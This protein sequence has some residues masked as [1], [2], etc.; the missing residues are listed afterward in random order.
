MTAKSPYKPSGR[1]LKYLALIRCLADDVLYSPAKIVRT[2][3]QLG[4]IE[5]T[6]AHHR[7]YLVTC[8][9]HALSRYAK[10]HNFPKHGD[11][12]V[13]LEGQNITA[14]WYGIRWKRSMLAPPS[15]AA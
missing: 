14:G 3:L 9:R 7:A 6:E 5:E 8:A 4:L 15:D 11:G 1:P 10:N 12:L 13:S 2:A